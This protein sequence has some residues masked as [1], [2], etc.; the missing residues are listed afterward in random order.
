MTE[1]AIIRKVL[2]IYKT[3]KPFIRYQFTSMMR[4]AVKCNFSLSPKLVLACLLNEAGCK[5]D[6]LALLSNSAFIYLF[7]ELFKD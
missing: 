2:S 4:D 1:D 7:D 5:G 6:E 3:D